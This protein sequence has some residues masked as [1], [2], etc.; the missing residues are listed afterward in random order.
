LHLH[1]PHFVGIV[2]MRTRYLVWLAGA[3]LVAPSAQA[4]QRLFIIANNADGYGVDRCLATGSS[5]G[6]AIAAAYCRAQDF[7]ELLT[8]RRIERAEI[9]GAVPND[10]PVCR[11][12]CEDLVAIECRR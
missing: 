6:K 5:C 1:E 10:A 7:A 11:G 3:L 8:F 2:S 12:L 4:E 9:T